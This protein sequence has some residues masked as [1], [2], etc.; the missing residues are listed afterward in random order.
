MSQPTVVTPDD[1]RRLIREARA[2]VDAVEALPQ[3]AAGE[4]DRAW[5]DYRAGSIGAR[6]QQLV[7]TLPGGAPDTLNTVLNSIV[8]TVVPL[9]DAPEPLRPAADGA[10]ELLNA[11]AEDMQRTLDPL[12]DRERAAYT[13]QASADI[14]AA[15]RAVAAE[16]GG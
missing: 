12:V 14:S 1:L 16:F 6:W 15:M 11:L 7:E 5:A 2:A 4:D 10:A 13:D 9:E 8:S 3:A